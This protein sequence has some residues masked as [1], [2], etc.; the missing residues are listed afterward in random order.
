MTMDIYAILKKYW[1]YSSF[2]PVQEDIIRSVL[3]GKDTL[4][5]LPTGG[6]KSICFQIPAL[7]KE[8]ICIVISPLI[9][10][11]KDQVESLLSKEIPASA[12]YSGLHPREIELILRDCVKGK[13]KFLYLAPER[14]KNELLKNSIQQMNVNLLAV[15]ESHCISQW[16]YD[17][18]PPYLEIA[19]FRELLPKTVPVLALT[20]TATEEVIKDIQLRLNFKTENVF[21]KS[22]Y[23]E[24]LTYYVFKEKNKL[25]R[26]LQIAS[27]TPGS[28]IVYVRRRKQTKELADFFNRNNISAD[29]YHAGLAI[30]ERGEKQNKW[31]TNKTRIIVA[32]N[33]FGMGIDKPDVRFIVHM[34]IPDN[35]EAYFQEAGR[36]G[37]DEQRAYAIL[38]YENEDII[39]LHK[40]FE[41][42]FP[43]VEKI[44]D[45]YNALC[46]YFQIPIGNG[47]SASFDFD[48]YGFVQK[49]KFN[50]LTVF[51]SLA[52][53]ERAGF[54][55][56]TEA[57]NNS[58]KIHIPVSREDLYRFQVE[59]EKYD[60]FIKLLLRSYAGLFTVFISIEE[61]HLAAHSG[62]SLPTVIDALKQLANRQVIIYQ[63]KTE[64]PRIIFL[65]NRI[66]S[67]YLFFSPQVYD[68]RK[69]IGE[70]RMEAILG[71]VTSNI[72]CRSQLLLE[73]FG[74]NKT[75]S[76][77]KCDV[78][79]RWKRESL[80]KKEFDTLRE[81]ILLLLQNEDL[82]IDELQEKLNYPE[83]QQLITTV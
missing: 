27:R 43:P 12:I 15:D 40:N 45:V 67:R 61:K 26:L 38:L 17:F 79:L 22:F 51:N 29:Y 58:S 37:R 20:A 34:D 36:G 16:G 39:N 82:T 63:P 23:R 30:K 11:M 24:N 6:G 70:E 56:M 59:N 4:A 28:G 64:N 75:V 33:A 14:L 81:N 8:G 57:V 41:E 31:K 35:I 19:A 2:R 66:E 72:K 21:R 54:I 60:S 10:L 13:I 5:L 1:K 25:K 69:R 74:E 49:Y 47:E 50:S 55:S 9:A 76:C 73:Y 52:F 46:N 48:T 44:R 65:Q 83:E 32:T 68:D 62:L 71:Y 42:S 18:R 3:E 7:A 78:C 77:E 80:T 53:I